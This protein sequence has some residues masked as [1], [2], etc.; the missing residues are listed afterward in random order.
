LLFVMFAPGAALIPA[1]AS[2]VWRQRSAPSVRFCLA[3]LVPSFLAFEA[4]AT[5][6]PHYTL[7]T[8][9]AIALLIGGALSAAAPWRRD[10][11]TA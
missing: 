4:V 10:C 5:K 6:L 9:P 8:Y 7:P 3:W 1:A 2:W 11:V